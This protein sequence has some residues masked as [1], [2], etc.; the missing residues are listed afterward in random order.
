MKIPGMVLVEPRRHEDTRGF[1]QESYRRSLFYE[2]GIKVNFVQ[3]N[4][5]R[6]SRGVLRGLHFQLPPRPQGKLVTVVRGEVFDVGVDLR[7]GSPTY[8]AWEG[9]T[10]TDAQGALLYLPPG[11]AHGYAVLSPEADLAYK[12]T[13]EYDPEL[14]TGILWNDPE[15]GVEWPLDDPLL[16]EKDRALPP[17][18]EFE[19][20]FT[21]RG[22]NG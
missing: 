9:V 5:A 21:F 2:G 19:S 11:L 22:G 6:S 8:G 17:L 10:L 4:L 20:P 13:A 12:V 16:S 7:V 3:D 14:D 15:V 18:G 1:F